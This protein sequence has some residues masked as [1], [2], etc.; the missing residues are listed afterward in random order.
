MHR[1]PMDVLWK[2]AD[3]ERILEMYME[4]DAFAIDT[5]T[6]GTRPPKRLTE[7]TKDKPAL[8]WTSNRV[9]W[10]SL[11]TQGMAHS[12]ACGHPTGPGPSMR[13]QMTPEELVGLLAPLL[14]SDK[15]KIGLNLKFDFL[16]LMKY[17]DG[18]IIPGPHSD[19]GVKAH[20]LNENLRQV[21]KNKAYGLKGLAE[22]IFK[23]SYDSLGKS[24]E[25]Y[26]FY[27]TGL[28]SRYDALFSWLINTYT[29][30]K[31]DGQKVRRV[32]NLEMEVHEALVPME[33]EGVLLDVKE[34]HQLDVDLSAQ[35]KEMEEELYGVA[36][37]DEPPPPPSYLTKKAHFEKL[38]RNAGLEYE[39][40]DGEWNLSS[41][42][43]RGWF[44][45]EVRKHKPWLFTEK[46]N[47]PST[48]EAAIKVYED[49]D[50]EVAKLMEWDD[51]HKLHS[52]YVHSQRMRMTEDGRL[53]A[54]FKQSGTKTGR[55]SCSDPN[56]QNIPRAGTPLGK[57]IRGLFVAPAGYVMVV[58]DFD[59][60]ELRILGHETQD[61]NLMGVFLEGRDPHTETATRIME[62]LGLDPATM[63]PEQRTNYGK[64]P[65]FAIVYGAGPSKLM[66]GTGMSERQARSVLDAL[67]A[68][69][70][71]VRPWT[72]WV[73]RD[74]REKGY[75]RTITGRKRRLPQINWADDKLRGYAE[76]QAVN[77]MIQGTAADINKMALV[78]FDNA[79]K[80]TPI[81]LVLSVHDELVAYAPTHMVEECSEL[82]REAMVGDSIQLLSVPLTAEINHGDRWSTAK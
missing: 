82:M 58:G 25:I 20:L 77:T 48:A 70:S 46:T 56:L 16:S 23:F 40:W 69:Y 76:R 14:D 6:V 55:F 59:Q 51:V 73:V 8:D 45:Y 62:L 67:F 42:N 61:P 57:K 22:R 4:A 36:F 53:H 78:R 13:E 28:Y 15:L 65:N 12:I 43:D 3:V 38:K 24:P 50:K 39:P 10:V 1:V 31:L 26:P 29:E 9:I 17:R 52:T 60:V 54:N 5:E 63:T 68:T 2:R 64:T 7:K 81:K 49:K 30:P 71:R 11:A 74:C 66:Q 79:I 27:E 75:V 44:V 47:L 35:L 72:A 32:W 80:G 18:R 21:N 19:V 41:T 33:W 34:I 37:F